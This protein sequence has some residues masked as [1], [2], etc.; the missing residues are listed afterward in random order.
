MT[1]D[2]STSRSF[3]QCEKKYCCQRSAFAATW[4]I[5]FVVIERVKRYV[6]VHLHCI[7]SNLKTKSKMSTL[8]TPAK[9]SADAHACVVC[10]YNLTSAFY[11]ARNNHYV[12]FDYPFG[13]VS[14]N[15]QFT[16]NGM[17][18]KTYT[19]GCSAN[20]RGVG[21]HPKKLAV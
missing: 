8:P 4:R 21:R 5:L 15:V 3:V 20:K 1:A 11:W 16:T 14:L 17:C 12:L 6:N 10:V 2:S 18:T 7:V 9:I 19:N 13:S